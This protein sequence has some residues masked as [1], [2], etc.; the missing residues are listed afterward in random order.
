MCEENEIFRSGPSR[1]HMAP[2]TFLVA[3]ARC[4]PCCL[5]VSGFSTFLEMVD[6]PTGPGKFLHLR[7]LMITFA[8]WRFSW[9][10][11]YFSLASFLDA[12][13]SLET[14]ILCISQKEKHDLTFKDP[15]CLRQIPEH[16]HDKLKN[17]KIT[18]FSATRSLVELI[19]HIMENTTSLE[20]LTLDTLCTQLR[21]SD[22]NIDVCLP[23]DQ[24]VI[25][26]VHNSLLAIRT[27]IEGKIPSTVKFNVRE[28]CS[29]CHGW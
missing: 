25:K 7:Y 28:P 27:Y 19:C 15:I 26:G 14:F 20:C 29:R 2:Y 23:L 13:P 17:V 18:G 10:Y 24:D 11:D 16:R 12:S 9:A 21:C 8:T 6:T 3:T 4:C 22:G 1:G 5:R